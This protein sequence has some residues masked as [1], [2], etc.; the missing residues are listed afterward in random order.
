MVSTQLSMHISGY[1]CIYQIAKI[2][3]IIKTV[4]ANWHA[5]MEFNRADHQSVKIIHL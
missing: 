5:L 4:K 2:P 3:L 1:T